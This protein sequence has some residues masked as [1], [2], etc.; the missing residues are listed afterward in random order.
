MIKVYI[1]DT[2]KL[3]DDILFEKIYINAPEKRKEKIDRL[4]FRN[5]KNLS[6]AAWWLIYS[7]L[8]NEGIDILKVSFSEYENHKP[9]IENSTL[10]FNLSHSGSKVI[11]ALSDKRIG[12]DIEKIN[13]KDCLSI[14]ERYFTQSEFNTI[15]T[16]D[17]E[18]KK[19]KMFYRI[20]TLKESFIKNTGLGLSLVLDSFELNL[21]NPVSINQSVDKNNYFFTEINTIDG[22]KCSVCALSEEKPEIIFT[23]IS[24]A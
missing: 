5:D 18:N 19:A 21:D 10:D 7:A 15:M 3:S 16:C 22:Y 14:A 20:W 11:C 4:K 13:E 6:L 2:E 23:D 1:A 24:Q 17:N 12:C 8:K 9:C